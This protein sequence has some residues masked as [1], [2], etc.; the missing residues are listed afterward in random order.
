MTSSLS[1]FYEPDRK[2]G[3]KTVHD[4]PPVKKNLSFLGKICEGYHQFK[5][6]FGLLMK[7]MKEHL[8]ND[9]IFI[10]R[11]NE[12]DVVWRFKDDL[13]SL[14]QWVVTCDSDYNEGFSTVKLEMSST[15]TG[16][17]SGM[18]STRLPKDGKI[19]YAGYCSMTSIPKRKSFKREVYHNWTPYTHLN[20]R[21]RGD[22]RCYM[23]TISTRGMFDLT[24]NDVY[25]YVLH[26]RG[27]PY[28]Q[29]VK[30]PFSKFIFAS[31]GSL[32]DKQVPIALEEVSNFGISLADD[33]PGHFKL[34]IDYIGLEY[35][36]FH[37]EEFAY[38]SYDVSRIRF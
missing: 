7:E 37:N 25:H 4:R 18:L 32:Q 12:V 6:E 22:G 21:V 17:F 2:S 16:V 19:K 8:K 14:D 10:Y 26:T 1:Y 31:K 20:L 15:G 13:K 9:P 29:Y 3:Y 24:W 5:E 23:L 33:V 30:V 28:W 35:D 27:G 38:E 36:E 34:E 11:T